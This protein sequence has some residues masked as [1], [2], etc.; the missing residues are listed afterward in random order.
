M[1]SQPNRTG[2]EKEL[3]KN[4]ISVL[5]RTNDEG[6]IYGATFI[7]HEQKAVFNGSRLGKEFSANVFNDLF[8]GKQ[9]Q[10]KFD[11]GQSFEPFN[12]SRRDDDSSVGS[13]FSLLSPE[14][15]GANPEEEAFARKA[16][17]KKRK[18]KRL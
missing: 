6:R 4:N 3:A 13:I 9:E 2:F 1:K 8:N 16:R 14:A 17:K 18:Q 10:P 15:H 7:D 12:T 11:T 5:F